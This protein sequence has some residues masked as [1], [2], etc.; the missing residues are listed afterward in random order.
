MFDSV[1][2]DFV[3]LIS[4]QGYELCWRFDTSGAK[5]VPK[6]V[7]VTKIVNTTQSLQYVT[8]ALFGAA[9]HY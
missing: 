2:R 7:K 5:N 9:Y 1:N 4:S 6:V 8:L 3:L